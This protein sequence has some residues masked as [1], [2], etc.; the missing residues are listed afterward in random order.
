MNGTQKSAENRIDP[1]T[2][3]VASVAKAHPKFYVGEAGAASSDKALT[4]CSTSNSARPEP[5]RCR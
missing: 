5:G 4:R 1:L 2:S 3:A